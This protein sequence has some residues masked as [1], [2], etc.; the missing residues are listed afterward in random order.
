MGIKNGFVTKNTWGVEKIMVVS[1]NPIVLGNMPQKGNEADNV[2]IAFM[3]QVP[4]RI[5]GKV[6]LGEYVLPSEIDDGFGKAV[7]SL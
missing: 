4:A 3:G 7:Q 1:T 6:E 2:K 5:I